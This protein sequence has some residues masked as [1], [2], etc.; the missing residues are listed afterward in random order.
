[1]AR[2]LSE[3]PLRMP[4]AAATFRAATASYGGAQ[5]WHLGDGGG[6]RSGALITARLAGELGWAVMVVPGPVDSLEHVGSNAEAA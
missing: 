6:Q 2:V 5:S 3:F 1:M 4:P